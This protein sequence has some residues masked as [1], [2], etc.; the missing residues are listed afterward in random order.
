MSAVESTMLT[1][2]TKA[3]DFK[4]PNVS[5]GFVNMNSYAKNSKGVVIMFLCNHCPYVKHINS[6]LV[7]LSKHFIQMGIPFVAISSND[8]TMYPDD[9]PD[10]MLQVMR[11]EGY[12]FPYLYDETQAVAKSFKAACTPDFYLFDKN[13]ELVYRGQFD[14]SRPGNNKPVT[15]RD[16]QTAIERLLHSESPVEQQV[17]SI[18]CNIKW[19]PGNEPDYFGIKK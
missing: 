17:P 16:L 11:E 2:G 1:L 12:S 7:E 15:G 8:V 14:N 18:G 5:G 9:S 6:K 3:P 13:L 10:K 4:L 19:I